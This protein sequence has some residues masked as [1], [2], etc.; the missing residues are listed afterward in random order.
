M[1]VK[2][3]REGNNSDS[4]TRYSVLS[5]LPNNGLLTAFLATCFCMDDCPS[6]VVQLTSH[7]ANALTLIA[8]SWSDS[9]ESRS[10][11]TYL[12]IFVSLTISARN[13]QGQSLPPAALNLSRVQSLSSKRAPSSLNKRVI[14][15]QHCLLTW[16][17]DTCSPCAPSHSV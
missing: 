14:V 3:G 8:F 4:H 9:V 13:L 2:G 7:Q 1:N 17:G 16:P 11:S 12:P 5:I 10:R 6:G 15:F